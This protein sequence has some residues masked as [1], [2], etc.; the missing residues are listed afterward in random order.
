MLIP[1]LL[2]A[3]LLYSH[4]VLSP[5]QSSPLPLSVDSSLVPLYSPSLLVCSFPSCF[6]FSCPLV[7]CFPCYLVATSLP[8]R[9]CLLL[10]TAYSLFSL[11][12]IPPSGQYKCLTLSALA[13][14]CSLLLLVCLPP[15]PST[16][17]LDLLHLPSS[18]P[19]HPL[20]C[21]PIIFC[22]TMYPPF[23]CRLPFLPSFTVLRVLAPASTYPLSPPSTSLF[24]T[25]LSLTR[26][27]FTDQSSIKNT[28]TAG[29][30]AA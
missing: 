26:R 1:P 30:M 18:P 19:H 16:A 5:L 24:S 7:Y 27:L 21:P 2:S 10:L 6:L 15:T 3:C 28:T 20:V 8:M 12:H 17:R 29:T 9:A 11:L 25:C 13:A 14:F 22:I 23:L 4:R